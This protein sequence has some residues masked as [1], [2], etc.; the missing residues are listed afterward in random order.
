[1]QIEKVTSIYTQ[2][3]SANCPEKVTLHSDKEMKS[4][5]ELHFA[6]YKD[7][8]KRP[9]IMTLHSKK[10]V[11]SDKIKSVCTANFSGM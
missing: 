4:D 6:S 1:V 9:E 5:I 8:T 10:R 11:R 7:S 3:P 2:P